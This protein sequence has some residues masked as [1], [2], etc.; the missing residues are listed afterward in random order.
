[1]E[2]SAKMGL[3]A[4]DALG[5]LVSGKSFYS[6]TNSFPLEIFNLT[7]GQ[8]EDDFTMGSQTEGRR[9]EIMA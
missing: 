2:V 4:K 5:R 3:G 1:M 7:T 9:T 8:V 6:L